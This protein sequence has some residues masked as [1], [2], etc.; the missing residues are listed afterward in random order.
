MERRNVLKGLL[1]AAV[2]AAGIAVGAQ[3]ATAAGGSGWKGNDRPG[4]GPLRIREQG[5]FAVGGTVTTT[6]GT[7][8]PRNPTNPAGQTLH[9]DH[10]RVFYQVPEAARKLPLVLWHGY[11][12]AGTSWG[13]TP[14]GRE[15]FQ[16]LFLRRRTRS[17][18]GPATPGRCRQNDPGH[19]RGHRHGRAMVLQPV[20]AR[21]LM[22]APE[23]ST[24]TGRRPH[25]RPCRG[26]GSLP[27]RIPP[28]KP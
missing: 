11:K 9:G 27:A 24:R 12:E 6:P 17:H 2:P 18:P 14:D 15:G 20:P 28:T 8:D 5:G 21:P 4:S 3:P 7:F 16:T 25:A 13:M 19:Q 23:C 26:C 22:N 1:A 10:S